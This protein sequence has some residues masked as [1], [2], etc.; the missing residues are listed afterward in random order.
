M[1]IICLQASRDTHIET[2]AVI[3]LMIN[4]NI[5][6]TIIII[7]VLAILVNQ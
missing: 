2:T 3:R 5:D 6:T 7:I 4:I 1:D